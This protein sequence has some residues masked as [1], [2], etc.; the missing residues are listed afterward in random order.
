MNDDV[1]IHRKK[2]NKK[3]ERIIHSRGNNVTQKSIYTIVIMQT[4]NTD[5]IKIGVHHVGMMEGNK[6]PRGLF[7]GG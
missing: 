7:D 3:N 5:L 1:Y 2:L 6:C 4:S